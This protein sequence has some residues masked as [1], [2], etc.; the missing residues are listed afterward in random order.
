[1]SGAPRA[2][3]SSDPQSGVHVR[4]VGDG[5]IATPAPGDDTA[6]TAT[7]DVTGE[8]AIV[9]RAIST[10][11]AFKGVGLVLDAT[12]GKL[13]GSFRAWDG[14]KTTELGPPVELGCSTRCRV[15]VHVKKNFLGATVQDVEIPA[16]LIP[17]PFA[18]GDVALAVKNGASIEASAWSVTK[19][20]AT[21]DAP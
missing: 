4:V 14:A 15:E 5:A 16:V 20:A 1:M 18:H 11:T 8:A 13:R 6:V 17:P 12:S 19:P 3:V 21:R 10:V 7:V 9:L 2:G